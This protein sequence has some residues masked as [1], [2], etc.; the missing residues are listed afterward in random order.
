MKR[1]AIK[2]AF[3]VMLLAAALISGGAYAKA[4]AAEGGD[5]QK[6]SKK[7]KKSGGGQVKFLRGS[8]EST[9]ERSSR[10]K[11]ECKGRVNAGACAGYT[12]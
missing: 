7:T 12:Q 11:R 2:P 8:E 4:Q 9:A 5:G 6:S 1:L 10:L 3:A